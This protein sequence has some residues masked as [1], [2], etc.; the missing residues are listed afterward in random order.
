MWEARRKSW[1]ENAAH[2]V[3]GM[4]SRARRDRRYLARDFTRLMLGGWR[5]R[6]IFAR[7]VAAVRPTSR[8]PLKSAEVQAVA[9]QLSDQGITAPLDLMT[10]DQAEDVRAYFL[11]KPYH[12]PYRLRLGWFRFPEAPSPDSNQAYYDVKTILQAPHL[13]DIANHPLVLAVAERI[14]GCKPT[15]DNLA[16]WWYFDQR[17]TAKGFQRFHRDL[18]TPRFFKLFVYLSDVDAESGAHVFVRGSHR[19]NR[20]MVRRYIDDDEVVQQYGADSRVVVSG[21]PGTTFL[22]DTSGVHKGGLPGTRPRLVFAAQYN[23][24][25]SPFGPRQPVA[26]LPSPRFDGYVNR[27]H[28]WN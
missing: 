22:V 2:E 19:S 26:P 1:F 13:M 12:D 14:L 28:Y 10:R 25:G 16:C 20:L 8:R 18:D 7:M 9:A 3:S 21:A 27:G 11:D 4:V 6:W 23:L 24:W 17:A 15:L 5:M